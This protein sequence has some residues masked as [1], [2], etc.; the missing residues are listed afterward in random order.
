MFSFRILLLG[1]LFQALLF[2]RA[3]SV[4]DYVAMEAARSGAL[5]GARWCEQVQHAGDWRGDWRPSMRRRPPIPARL[6]RR[7]PSST[8]RRT[9]CW[10]WPGSR[11]SHRRAPHGR[12]LRQKQYDG[13]LA[14]FQTFGGPAKCNLIRAAPS[15]A[16][17]S[18]P[19]RW[20]ACNRRRRTRPT[21]RRDRDAARLDR[22]GPV[23]LRVRGVGDRR[24]QGAAVGIP[25]PPSAWA[26]A[27][28]T[29]ARK[30]VGRARRSLSGKRANECAWTSPWAPIA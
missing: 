21:A 30:T 18:S 9:S 20:C 12:G 1:L 19:R 28:A 11:C 27:I 10:A 17:P 6:A 13:K 3:K 29:W 16:R 14:A 2:Y 8:R 7:W 26:T 4:V 15:T 24:N 22:G 25:S 5:H 23:A